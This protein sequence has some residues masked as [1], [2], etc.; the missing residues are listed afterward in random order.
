MIQAI[1]QVCKFNYFKQLPTLVSE[2][3]SEIG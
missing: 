3:R 2:A 1:L